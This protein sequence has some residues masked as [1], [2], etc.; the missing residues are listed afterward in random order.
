M[1]TGEKSSHSP[2]VEIGKL[3]TTTFLCMITELYIY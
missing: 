1:L 2:Q 3:I